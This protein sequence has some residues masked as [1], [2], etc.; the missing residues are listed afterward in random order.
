MA[1]KKISKKQL[2]IQNAILTPRQ[3]QILQLVQQ[4]RN[5]NG[6]SPTLQEMAENLN[7]S[8]V[9]VFEHVKALVEKGLLHREANKAR[10]LI[11]DK[12]I[13]LQQLDDEEL[14]QD[15]EH[16]DQTAQEFS[17]G[18]YPLAGYIAA[19]TPLEALETPD[20]I[21]L[22]T[23]FETPQGTFAL[24][25]CGESMI[26][27]HICDGDYVLIEK[28]K[29]ARDGEIVVAILPDGEAT[30]KK[31]YREK[32]GFRLQGANPEFKP[33]HTPY[34]DVQGIVVGVLRKF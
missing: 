25:V 27:E 6:C 9:T 16:P 22:S 8:K 4:Y 10:S 14:D 33:I 7:I 28:C 34:V 2:N 20:V 19:G 3:V 13:D 24:K 30:L 26:E 1:R 12:S 21:D 32:N 17:A 15:E 5:S 18:E 11:L 31:L 29:T 23:M